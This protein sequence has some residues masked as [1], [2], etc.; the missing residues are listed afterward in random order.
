MSLTTYVQAREAIEQTTRDTRCI[1]SL[2]TAQWLLGERTGSHLNSWAC[3]QSVSA[4]GLLSPL[5]DVYDINRAALRAAYPEAYDLADRYHTW[6]MQPLALPLGRQQEAPRQ[7]QLLQKLFV[8]SYD[9]EVIPFLAIAE[10]LSRLELIRDQR[11]EDQQAIIRGARVVLLPLLERYG[12]WELNQ[13]AAERL[14]EYETSSWHT[15]ISNLVKA[16]EERR[17]R[18]LEEALHL[19]PILPP[20]ATVT[21]HQ[22]RPSRIYL[23]ALEHE[24]IYGRGDTADLLQQEAWRLAI[25]ITVQ[26]QEQC[27]LALGAVHSLWRPVGN[28]IKDHIGSPKFNGYQ[29]LHILVKINPSS[30]FSAE[31]EFFIASEKMRQINAWG[32]IAELR[33]QRNATAD[34]NS[35][36]NA[37]WHHTGH[38]RQLLANHIIGDYSSP[39]YVFSPVGEIFELVQLAT[40]I[41]YAYAVHSSVGNSYG[42]AIV[43]ERAVAPDFTLANGDIVSIQTGPQGKTPGR[44]NWLGQAKSPQAAKH[45]RREFS[46]QMRHTQHGRDLI[47]KALKEWCARYGVPFAHVCSDSYLSQIA[48]RWSPGGLESFYAA[49]ASG[50]VDPE[51]VASH[52]ISLEMTHRVGYEDGAALVLRPGGVQIAHCCRPTMGEAIVGRFVQQGTKHERVKI[53]KSDCPMVH[54]ALVTRLIW[55]KA[56]FKGLYEYAVTGFDRAGILRDVLQP[57]YESQGY[58]HKVQAERLPDE[59]AQFY[60]VVELSDPTAAE[61]LKEAIAHVPDITECTMRPMTLSPSE[62]FARRRKLEVINP[63]HFE[64]P[65]RHKV[66]F[67]GRQVE[68]ARLKRLIASRSG[69]NHVVISGAWRVGKTSLLEYIAQHDHNE[70]GAQAVLVNCHEVPDLSLQ[71]LLQAMMQAIRKRLTPDIDVLGSYQIALGE[72]DYRDLLHNPLEGFH[73]FLERVRPMLNAGDSRRLVIM[74]DEFSDLHD[75]V[76]QGKLDRSIFRNL[77]GLFER[78]ADIVFITVIQAAALH[79]MQARYH[80]ELLEI[81][82]SIHLGSLDDDAIQELLHRRLRLL[83]LSCDPVTIQRVI[84]EV[85]GNPYVINILCHSVV[86]HL[87]ETGETHIENAH[88]N[89]AIERIMSGQGGIY[90]AHLTHLLTGSVEAAL[91]RALVLAGP[92]DWCSAPHLAAEAAF[93][94]AVTLAETESALDRLMAKGLVCRQAG[95]ETGAMYKIQIPLFARWLMESDA[96]QRR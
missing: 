56:D 40:P 45:L 87:W 53:H 29:A 91:L 10:A 19:Q 2:A 31:V 34:S 70:F 85:G 11:L 76:K 62:V 44:A 13:Y 26:T 50:H 74:I 30:D 28:F 67:V 38:G 35:K 52:V 37:W 95:A 81:A 36:V 42:G 24:D 94:T 41:D 80:A 78:E 89:R 8:A 3:P 57:F 83:N 90:F 96:G 79:E 84:R 18:V 48:K 64:S 93:P 59:S 39:T 32:R 58:L 88:I 25:D 86:E 49:A 16:A 68:L 73:L 14:F 15:A 51:A 55:R 71:T 75:D 77:R 17:Q 54:D 92:A 20:G 72:G 47:H 22:V 7:V 60:F 46:R 33:Q 27:Y 1:S 65:A 9:S 43:N 82:A 5:L 4:A 21:L 6:K 69:P 12:L 23:H 63:F 61:Q 66:E